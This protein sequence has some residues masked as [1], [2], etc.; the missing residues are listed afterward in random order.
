MC[1]ELKQFLNLSRPERCVERFRE[2]VNLTAKKKKK[3]YV[4][5]FIHLEPKI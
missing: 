1:P 5:I 4:F 3:N 2:S